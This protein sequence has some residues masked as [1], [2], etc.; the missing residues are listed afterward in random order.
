MD[1]PYNFMHT[2]QEKLTSLQ[3]Q[4]NDRLTIFKQI[5]EMTKELIFGI[6]G[7]FVSD[8]FYKSCFEFKAF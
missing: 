1:V 5:E 8:I 6:I 4:T 7:S 3:N 2:L